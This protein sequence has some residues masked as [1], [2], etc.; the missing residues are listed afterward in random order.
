MGGKVKVIKAGAK[1][2][3]E[4]TDSMT[5]NSTNNMSK[6]GTIDRMMQTKPI[7]LE[8]YTKL[9]K[10]IRPNTNNEAAAMAVG[11]AGTYG[12]MKAK[13]NKKVKLEKKPRKPFMNTKVR[14]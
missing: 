14:D 5:K 9:A 4:Y 8:Q 10:S 3:R 1:R 7:N 2:L 12:V 6:D 11:A 13:E